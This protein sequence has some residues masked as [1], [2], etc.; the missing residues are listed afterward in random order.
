MKEGLQWFLIVFLIIISGYLFM[1]QL[2]LQKKVSQAESM[3][4][5][6]EEKALVW[7]LVTEVVED[8]MEY[9]TL[10]ECKK[11]YPQYAD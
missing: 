8:C 5:T 7:D 1:T 10:G 11:A 4:A 6:Y 9:N 2:E 3:L